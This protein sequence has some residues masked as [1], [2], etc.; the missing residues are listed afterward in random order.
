M[1]EDVD[2][3]VQP[4]QKR[5]SRVYLAQ[6]DLLKAIHY[7]IPEGFVSNGHSLPPKVSLPVAKVPQSYGLGAYGTVQKS[8]LDA[9]NSLL[10]KPPTTQL[11]G[12][13]QLLTQKHVY[14]YTYPEVS[15]PTFVPEKKEYTPIEE[16]VVDVAN[17]QSKPNV[18]VQ[19]I[20][21]D[22]KP[23]KYL[24]LAKVQA[25]QENK[26]VENVSTIQKYNVTNKRKKRESLMEQ[27][28]GVPLLKNL[29]LKLN[30]S[31]LESTYSNF[32]NTIKNPESSN[33]DKVVQR[34]AQKVVHKREA[35][36][37]GKVSSRNKTEVL[38]EMVAPNLEKYEATTLKIENPE[39][40]TEV[41]DEDYLEEVP[42]ERS[43]Y[44][45]FDYEYTELKC[46]ENFEEMCTTLLPETTP[47]VIGKR[48]FNLDKKIHKME[49]ALGLVPQKKTPPKRFNRRKYRRYP[50]RRRPKFRKPPPPIHHPKEVMNYRETPPLEDYTD[51][52]AE[53]SS[54]SEKFAQG[55]TYKAPD[56]TIYINMHKDDPHG[57]SVHDHD[58]HDLHVPHN[59]HDSHVPL[60]PDGEEGKNIIVIN[61][62]NDNHN[63]GG[64]AAI[65]GGHGGHGKHRVKYKGHRGHRG[66]RGHHR[67]RK[68]SKAR[69]LTLNQKLD[70]VIEKLRRKDILEQ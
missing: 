56:S 28:V 27:V 26:A 42:T 48:A 58:L 70:H 8:Q 9:L 13:N 19:P 32:G 23:Q 4:S 17:T 18:V 59:L 44:E 61:N 49:V 30:K 29:N 14:A 69:L 6:D 25:T 54:E 60:D 62:S 37:P 21:I 50:R 12:L 64:N 51:Y 53:F 3:E 67:H 45:E 40:T 34:V 16:H 46:D 47:G 41:E 68:M 2:Q 66:H 24:E 39:D 33:V 7:P 20:Q 36:F 63:H 35:Q 43:N 31:Y 52:Y 65:K 55:Y 5:I 38:F 15:T 10:N 22:T 11:E 1:F 57:Y